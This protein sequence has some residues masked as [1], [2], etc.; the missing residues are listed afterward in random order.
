[1]PENVRPTEEAVEVYTGVAAPKR[2]RVDEQQ[3]TKEMPKVGGYSVTSAQHA[4]LTYGYPF[5]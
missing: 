2:R 3:I 5:M 1:M 4:V